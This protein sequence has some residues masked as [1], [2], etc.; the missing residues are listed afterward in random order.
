MLDM[1]IKF[2]AHDFK[3]GNWLPTPDAKVAKPPTAAAGSLAG[4]DRPK[5]K[6]D[7]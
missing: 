6:A 3:G 1:Q 7:G 4:Y 5:D 2:L